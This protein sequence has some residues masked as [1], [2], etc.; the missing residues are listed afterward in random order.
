MDLKTAKVLVTGGASGIGLATARLLISQ[1]AQ[2]A[3]C[4]RGRE[5]LNEAA[6][7]IGAT[8][9]I[10]D[11]SL[12]A[13]AVRMVETVID[14]FGDYNVLV[15]NAAIPH[16]A[17]LLDQKADEFAKVL[18]INVTG[19][20]LVARESAKHFVKQ[21]TGNII[22]IASTAGS[23]GFAGGSAYTA[24]KFA[25]TAL[26]ECWRAE[27]RKSN[28]RVMQINPSEVATHFGRTAE[29]LEQQQAATERKIQAEDIADTVANVLKLNDRA[30]VTALSVWATNP[31]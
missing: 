27:L 26:T 3:I 2:V 30:F 9:I 25:L 7:E 23:R 17:L 13:D 6:S 22:N 8:A 4:G 31:D 29:Q 10:A 21:N 14:A 24:S 12:E 18:A 11:V 20:M 15:N 19:A 5:R 16:Y 28:V 1:G